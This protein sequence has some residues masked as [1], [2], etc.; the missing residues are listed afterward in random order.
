[1]FGKWTTERVYN[2]E[3]KVALREDDE[4]GAGDEK[5][6]DIRCNLNKKGSGKLIDPLTLNGRMLLSISGY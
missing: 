6:E 5:E 4:E 1:M 2:A 3:K